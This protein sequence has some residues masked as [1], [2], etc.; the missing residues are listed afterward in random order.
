MDSEQNEIGTMNT[1]AAVPDNASSEEIR[2]DIRGTR[3]GMDETLDELGERLHPRHLLEDVID[4]FR[5][6]GNGAANSQVARTSKEVGRT[7]SR[8][9]REHP[10]P[11]LLVGAGIAWWIVDAVSD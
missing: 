2:Q 11:A 5:G 1:G 3:R 7:V 9:V 6:G 4:L 8:A 10:L